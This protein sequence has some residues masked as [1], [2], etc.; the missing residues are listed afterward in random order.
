MTDDAFGQ[1]APGSLSPK[2]EDPSKGPWVS[3]RILAMWPTLSRQMP[4]TVHMHEPV[5]SGFVGEVTRRSRDSREPRYQVRSP[6]RSR[7]RL[8]NPGVAGRLGLDGLTAYRV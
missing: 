6:F 1:R 4:D 2:I 3:W 8:S 5:T 7:K